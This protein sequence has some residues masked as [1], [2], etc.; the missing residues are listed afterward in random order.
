MPI[1]S[2]PAGRPRFESLEQLAQL[3]S[4]ELAAADTG[5]R[6]VTGVGGAFGQRCSDTIAGTH[7]DASAVGPHC[8]DARLDSTGLP[9]RLCDGGLFIY[10]KVWLR[11][12]A[13]Y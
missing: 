12:I 2:R 10:P 1:E 3:E 8:A 7:R 4:G 5:Q 9:G 13:G 6:E 11:G